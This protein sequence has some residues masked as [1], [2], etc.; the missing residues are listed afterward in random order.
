[1]IYEE[2]V[3]NEIETTNHIVIRKKRLFIGLWLLFDLFFKEKRKLLAGMHITCSMKCL[4]EDR[5]CHN[6]EVARVIYKKG[7]NF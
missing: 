3:K 2:S 5:I 4:L 7:E 1:M 6:R